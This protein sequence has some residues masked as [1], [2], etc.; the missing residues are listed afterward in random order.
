M[1]C[2]REGIPFIVENPHSFRSWRW[3][4]MRTALERSG[5]FQVVTHLCTFDA[6][7]VKPTRLAG[8]CPLLGALAQ[9]CPGH[10]AHVGKVYFPDKTSAFCTS[11]AAHY[12]PAFAA[13]LADALLDAA[14]EKAKRRGDEPRLLAWW[15]ESLAA[16]AGLP[17]SGR[18]LAAEA[19]VR[20]AVLGWEGAVG[21]WRGDP[22]KHELSV[23]NDIKEANHGAAGKDP[24]RRTTAPATRWRGPRQAAENGGQARRVAALQSRA[25]CVRNLVSRETAPSDHDARARRRP[26]RLRRGPLWPGRWR[27]ERAV[28]HVRRVLLV[29]LAEGLDGAALDQ[30]SPHR[31]QQVQPRVLTGP[32]AARGRMVYLRSCFSRPRPLGRS[33]SSSMVALVRCSPAAVRMLETGAPTNVAPASTAVAV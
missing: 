28:R 32:A 25:C 27:L 21:H 22:V 7:W 12:P 26:R 5:A 17:R 14:G 11:F 24:P 3:P 8:T 31:L 9:R 33:C 1:A 16:N 19:A 2:S 4:A 6:A 20:E 30:E 15:E 18:L 23:L 13:G 29:G 10:A